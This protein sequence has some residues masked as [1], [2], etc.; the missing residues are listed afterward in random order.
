MLSR[1]TGLAIEG[2]NGS[3]EVIIVDQERKVG[4]SSLFKFSPQNKTM[5]E[6]EKNKADGGKN[7]GG[8]KTEVI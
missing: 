2:K 7:T 6:K 5:I 8:L 4:F 1:M 3:N